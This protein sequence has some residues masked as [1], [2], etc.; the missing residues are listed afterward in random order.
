MAIYAWDHWGNNVLVGED[1]SEE[2]LGGDGNDIIIADSGNDTLR[3]QNDNDILFGDAG[4]DTLEGGAGNDE[5]S[6]GADHDELFGGS[7]DD[8][9]YFSGE[10]HYDGDSGHDTFSAEAIGYIAA[11]GIA[12]SATI[13]HGSLGSGIRMDLENGVAELRNTTGAATEDFY[14]EG[15]LGIGLGDAEFVSIEEYELTN[16]G[17]YFAGDNSADTIRGLGGNDILEG[18]GGA[19]EFFGGTGT[20]T[21]EYGSAGFDPV[22]GSGVNVDLERGTGLIGDAEGDTYDSI[23]NIRGSGRV[24]ALY[25]TDQ[26]NTILGRDGDDFIE[27]RGGADILDGG[28]G[29]DTALY[30]SSTSGVSIDLRQELQSLGDAASDRL[31]SIEHVDGS[32]FGDTIVGNSGVNH[33]NGSDGDDRIDGGFGNDILMGGQN[34]DTVS[35]ETWDPTGLVLVEN[36]RIQ[37]GEGSQQ[38]TATRSAMNFSTFTFSVVETDT[39]LGFENVR[40]SNRAET[41]IGNSG[42]NTIEGRGS[43]DTID[44]GRGNDTL[45]GGDGTDTASFE[46]WDPAA[47]ELTNRLESIR[48]ELGAVGGQGSA[49]WS[50]TG[51]T[52]VESDTLF[53][54][55]NVRGSN[56]AETIVGNAGDNT[57]EGRGGNDVIDGRGGA[58]TMRGGLGD[59]TYLVDNAA[60]A[61]T[62]NGGQGIDTV[63]TSVNFTLTSGA[64]VE[65]LTTTNDGGTA[66]LT[67]LGNGSGNIV[68]G[69]NGNNVI[70]GGNGDDDLTGLGG[71]DRFLFDTALDAANNIDVITDFNVA[72]DTIVLSSAVF[73]GLGSGVDS[74]EFV[75]GTAALDASDRIIYN[76]QTGDLLFDRDGVGGVAAIQFAEVT[77]GLALTHLDFLLAL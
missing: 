34:T 58:D 24:D 7:G 25:G 29:E 23:E 26:A 66:A 72:D 28:A 52:V 59:D 38:G 16:S 18:R 75:I 51:I 56:R 35:F 77:P 47:G 64:D 68:R 43:S 57:I 48:I 73:T 46:S 65:F 12:W 40:G 69:N 3:G 39:L 62:E 63:R 53:G 6:G 49:T 60:D 21:V 33:L 19:D 5:L 27:G 17:D 36:I 8:T 45:D 32:A 31:R 61:I 71:Q 50:L 37:L 11:G 13:T 41:I 67:L 42:V 1:A 44:G 30:T 10:D 55:E 9:L 14:L 22:T 54:F 4:E 20:D 15:V 2:F 70:G 76:S 74:N